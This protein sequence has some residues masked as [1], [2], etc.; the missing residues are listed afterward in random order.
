MI[1]TTLKTQI[2]FCLGKLKPGRSH[3]GNLDAATRAYLS[4]VN[5]KLVDLRR[6]YDQIKKP[7]HSC[8]AAWE[9]YVNLSRFRAE[10]DYLSQAYF[11]RSLIRYRMTAAYVEAVDRHGWLRSLSEDGNFGAKLWRVDQ[12]LH[13][14]RDLLDS[15]LELCWLEEFIGWDLNEAIQVL[16]IGAGYG[17]FAHRF[18]NAFPNGTITCVDAIATSTF[19]CDFYLRYRQCERWTVAPFDKIGELSSGRFTLATNVHSWSEMPVDWVRLW[20]DLLSDLDVPYLFL[21][22]N[23]EDLRTRELDGSLGNFGYELERHSYRCVAKSHKYHRSDIME[24]FGVYP[25]DY[26]LFERTRTRKREVPCGT[27][28]REP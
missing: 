14:S 24:R 21:V 27:K 13:V 10:N 19:L 25:T 18:T 17:R 12:D 26:Y 16:D 4:S 6:R 2:W 1:S 3:E 20:L 22:P 11:S 28:S 8:W 9:N 7:G 5:Q 15:I 23:F